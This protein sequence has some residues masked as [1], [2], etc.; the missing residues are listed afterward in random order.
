[1]RIIVFPFNIQ[2][3]Q[4]EVSHGLKYLNSVAEFSILIFPGIWSHPL[5]QENFLYKYMTDIYLFINKVNVKSTYVPLP[6]SKST[7]IFTGK[8][9]NVDNY[10]QCR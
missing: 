2:L 10:K 3:K 7:H 6:P 9:L 8:F 4:L 5:L 1:M